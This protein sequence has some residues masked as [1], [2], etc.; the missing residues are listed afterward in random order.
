MRS[1]WAV[2]L[3]LV[4]LAAS[5]CGKAGATIAGWFGATDKPQ[6][7][8][9][10][11]DVLCDPSSG[12]TCSIE[13]LRQAVEATLRTAAPRPGSVVRLWMQGRNIE[14]TR[15]IAMAKSSIHR[16][17]GRR[18]RADA[19]SR[20]LAK[21]CAAFSAAATAAMRKRIRRSPI[22]ESIGVVALS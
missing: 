10:T 8:P 21:E 15:I 17:T 12:S 2:A 13:A 16:V 1:V 5:G 14:T 7:V 3:A 18:A 6:A 4:V 9:V 22:A 20:W 11:I 19:E